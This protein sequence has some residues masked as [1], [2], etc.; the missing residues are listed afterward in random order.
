MREKF[1]DS[2][3]TSV[4]FGWAVLDELLRTEKLKALVRAHEEEGDGYK[5]HMWDG[6]KNDPTCITIFSAPNYCNHENNAAVF[7]VCPEQKSRVLTYGE[8]SYTMYY[9]RDRV[10]A[11]TTF[12]P[13]LV[14]ETNYILECLVQYLKA[15]TPSLVKRMSMS[16]FSIKSKTNPNEAVDLTEIE[17]EKK[18]NELIAD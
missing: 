18:S 3:C 7:L 16:T 4:K 5:F 11:L 15:P 17:E 8:S 1:N 12:I 13:A 6:N 2:R 14:E 10:D 9:L